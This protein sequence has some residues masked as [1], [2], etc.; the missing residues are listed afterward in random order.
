M[1]V[2]FGLGWV[3]KTH[4]CVEAL[5]PKSILHSKKQ[6]FERLQRPD[7]MWNGDLTK[8]EMNVWNPGMRI[9]FQFRSQKANTF[10]F[11]APVLKIDHVRQHKAELNTVC[12]VHQCTRSCIAPFILNKCLTKNWMSVCRIYVQ[13][14]LKLRLLFAELNIYWSCHQACNTRKRLHR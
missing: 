5:W 6:R 3:A 11:I 14:L 7:K 4:S 8:V 2:I 10:I 1:T 12:L 13:Y 9:T